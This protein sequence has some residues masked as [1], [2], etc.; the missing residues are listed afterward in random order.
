MGKSG[1]LPHNARELEHMARRAGCQL[2]NG[3]RHPHIVTPTGY[4]VP[5]P[6]HPGDLARGTMHSILQKLA[7]AGVVLGTPAAVLAWLVGAA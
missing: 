5:Y 2:E 4:R 6:A 1:N 7:A 3:G